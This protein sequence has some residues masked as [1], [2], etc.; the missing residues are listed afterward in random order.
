MVQTAFTVSVFDR[1]PCALT[2]LV[3]TDVISGPSGS[4]Y[5]AVPAPASRDGSTFTWRI[6][7]LEPGATATFTITVE[8]PSGVRSG[9]YRDEL[10]AAGKCGDV[11]VDRAVTL[12]QPTIT[13]AFSGPCDLS[14]SNKSATHREVIAG[15][16][17]NYLVHVFNTGGRP[18][19]GTTLVDTLDDR[20][21]FVACSDGCTD[22][23]QEVT[24]AGTTVPGGGGTTRTITVR[25]RDGATG[26]LANAAV[27]DS[28]D[29][30]GEPVRVVHTGP[31]VT[32]Q[33]ILLGRRR[34]R[35][36]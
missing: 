24:W 15:Q 35:L 23:G 34:L 21:E 22:N 2:E 13:N 9:R 32:D 12:D 5:T 29:D 1:G 27:I 7:K 25:V 33:S 10:R 31:Q 11:P 8:V 26:V 16:T 20:L 17:F 19:A 14:R 3:V 18:C 30:R 28:P 36:R 4:T 6:D